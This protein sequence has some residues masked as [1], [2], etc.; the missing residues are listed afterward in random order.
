VRLAA[1][2]A[3]AL[4]LFLVLLLVTPPATPQWRLCPFHALTG[5]D[6]PFCGL[7]RALFALAKGHVHEALRF[8]ALVPL[9]ASMMVAL[10]WRGPWVG[11]F[12][13]AGIGAFGVYGLWR[14]LA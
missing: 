7:T 12:W 6:C 10:W 3:A 13:R 11:R 2:T 5:L 14:I 8:H 9:A 4:G 1:K